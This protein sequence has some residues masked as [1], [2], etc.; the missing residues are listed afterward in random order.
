MASTPEQ[1]Y[2]KNTNYVIYI[3]KLKKFD[4]CYQRNCQSENI[5]KSL[6]IMHFIFQKTIFKIRKIFNNIMLKRMCLS[7]PKQNKYSKLISVLA[8][9]DRL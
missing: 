8:K 4:L 5:F 6:I 9:D 7:N 3:Y 1:K 2:Y